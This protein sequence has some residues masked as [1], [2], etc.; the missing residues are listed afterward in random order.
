VN[1]PPA[2]FIQIDRIAGFFLNH[3]VFCVLLF[4]CAIVLFFRAIRRIAAIVMTVAVMGMAILVGWK[5]MQKE[6]VKTPKVLQ[7]IKNAVSADSL[8]EKT[9][10]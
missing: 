6:G 7:E 8:A 9:S 3:P 10:P 4:L 2:L 5:W 1:L